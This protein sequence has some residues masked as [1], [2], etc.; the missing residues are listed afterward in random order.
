MLSIKI[1]RVESYWPPASM[2]ISRQMLGLQID[3]LRGIRTLG[4]R[5]EQRVLFVGAAQLP[6]PQRQQHGDQ[7]DRQQRRERPR[8]EDAGTEFHWHDILPLP[9]LIQA[10]CGIQIPG[11]ADPPADHRQLGQGLVSPVEQQAL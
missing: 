1:C 7:D 4:E 9:S 8:R 10:A 11:S 2:L 6:A 3:R 5:I